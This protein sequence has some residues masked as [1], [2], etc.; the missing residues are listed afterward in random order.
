MFM[1]KT[2]RRLKSVD[3]NVKERS[4]ERKA[5]SRPHG[6]WLHR[7]ETRH[8]E[9]LRRAIPRNRDPPEMAEPV[10]RV[11]AIDD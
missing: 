9:P 10:V 8:L 1:S 7:P 6:G 11:S 5:I 3:V 4:G 2:S